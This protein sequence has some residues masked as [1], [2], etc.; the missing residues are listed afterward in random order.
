MGDPSIE[1]T[2]ESRDAAQISK[3]KA[4]DAISEGIFLHVYFLTFLFNVFFYFLW[5]IMS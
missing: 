5:N 4:I 2:E 1:V 3:S